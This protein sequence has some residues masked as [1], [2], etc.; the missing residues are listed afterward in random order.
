MDTNTVTRIDIHKQ[1]HID[2]LIVTLV[3]CAGPTGV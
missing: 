3:V 1:I 2:T